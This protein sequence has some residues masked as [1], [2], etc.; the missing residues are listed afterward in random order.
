M[1]ELVLETNL[2]SLWYLRINIRHSISFCLRNFG[3]SIGQRIDVDT[4]WK[5]EIDGAN[6]INSDNVFN[7]VL[8]S[9]TDELIFVILFVPQAECWSPIYSFSLNTNQEWFIVQVR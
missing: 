3:I 6:E 9:E 4:F 1:A 8:D 7:I 2:F 5:F